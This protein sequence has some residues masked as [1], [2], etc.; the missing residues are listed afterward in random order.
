MVSGNWVQEMTIPYESKRMHS[1]TLL[2]YEISP[3]K[4]ILA[5]TNT[6]LTVPILILRKRDRYLSRVIA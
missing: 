1:A 6:S 5:R 4:I 2:S 3:F